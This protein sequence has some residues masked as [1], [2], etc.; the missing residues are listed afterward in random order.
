MVEMM[1]M[2]M[3]QRP[4]LSYKRNEKSSFTINKLDNC[5]LRF[6]HKPNGLTLAKR[7]IIYHLW[8]LTRLTMILLL[9][10]LQNRNRKWKQFRFMN[11]HKS[12]LEL[13]TVQHLTDAHQI[14]YISILQFRLFY[15][16]SANASCN[17]QMY[18]CTA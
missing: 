7:A 12:P 13:I 18:I 2:T 16:A 8:L 3:I 17:V 14:L 4:S 10:N 15:P 11:Y 6:L 9:I 5:R 1:L